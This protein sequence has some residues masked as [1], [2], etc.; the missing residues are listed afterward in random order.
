MFLI[1]SDGGDVVLLR[2][3]L[4]ALKIPA[5]SGRRDLLVGPGSKQRYMDAR[6]VAD[7]IIARGR[8]P[9]ASG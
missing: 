4:S 9:G 6:T 5:A 1:G 2:G 7:K 8:E 3:S